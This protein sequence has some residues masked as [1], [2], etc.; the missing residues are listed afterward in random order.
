[1]KKVVA[2]TIA[3]A[4]AA[5]IAGWRRVQRDNSMDGDRVSDTPEAG[6]E[7]GSGSGATDVG[8]DSTKAEL[9]EVA[10]ELE[11]EGRSS[12]TKAELLKAIRAAG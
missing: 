6:A 7:G 8:P 12:M 5:L 2:L 9:Y 1:M 11:I 4:A 10:Q 3:G